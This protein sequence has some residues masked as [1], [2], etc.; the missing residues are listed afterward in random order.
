MLTECLRQVRVWP[1]IRKCAEL[2]SE[3]YHDLRRRGRALSQVDILLAAL[4]THIGAVL[5]TTDRDFEAVPGI[6]Q[7]SWL[8]E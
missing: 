2:Y 3:I 8:R 1:S 5:V 6:R 7:E 4:A